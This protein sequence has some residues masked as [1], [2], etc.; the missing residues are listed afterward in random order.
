[1]V[2]ACP[3]YDR[4]SPPPCTRHLRGRTSSSAV[5][6]P[7]L[8]LCR[9]LAGF[10]DEVTTLYRVISEGI[11]SGKVA[12]IRRHVTDML[13]GELKRQVKTR[14]AGGWDRVQWE[15]VRRS[16]TMRAHRFP[17]TRDPEGGQ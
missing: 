15:L 12:D 14:E 1:M 5:N 7:P 13:S 17:L 4:W 3:R 9:T 6:S 2:R 16:V 11:A 8:R 10:K